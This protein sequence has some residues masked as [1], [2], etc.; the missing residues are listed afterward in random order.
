WCCATTL[1]CCNGNSAA[2]G[3]GSARLTGRYSPRSYADCHARPCTN[4]DCWSTRTR[5]CAGTAT[6]SADATPRHP[7]RNALAG[8]APSD[9]IRILVLRLAKENPN[10][11][12]RRIHGE[13]LVLG[14]KIAAS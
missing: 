12:Y 13:L 7:D 3:C 11:G 9:P 2:R 5:S 8:H 10:W 6:Y 14:I 4:S 1:Q